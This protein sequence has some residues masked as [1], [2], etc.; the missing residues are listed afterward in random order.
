MRRLRREQLLLAIDQ[1]RGIEGRELESVAMRNGIGRAGLNA[2]SA[3]NAAV[4]IDVVYLGVALGTADALLSSILGSFD[5]DAVRRTVRCAQEAGNTFLQPVLIAL[6]D[7]N[8]AKTLLELRATQRP[9]TVGIVLN[10]GGLEHL[11]E[12][13][14]HAFGD[15]GDILKDR[16]AE[17]V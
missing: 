3:K 4:V 6:Q 9:L 5:V 8:A 13:D 14:A 15:G 17:L 10:N 11:L 12:G 7:V 16:H 2:V 1:I